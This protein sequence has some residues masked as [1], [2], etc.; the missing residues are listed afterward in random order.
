[1]SS[2]VKMAAG[3][4]CRENRASRSE[5]HRGSALWPAS[6]LQPTHNRSLA[7]TGGT[8]TCPGSLTGPHITCTVISYET[9]I[10]LLFQFKPDKVKYL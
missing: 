4:Q 10:I 9:S 6:F 2:F 3:C 7:P 5:R 8:L 1:M